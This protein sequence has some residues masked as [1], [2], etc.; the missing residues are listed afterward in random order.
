MI[1]IIVPIYKVELYLSSC[2]D[3]ILNQTYKDFEVILVDDGSPDLCPVICDEYAKKDKRIKVVHKDNG[4][5]SSARNAGLEIARGEYIAFVDS[6]DTI[7]PDMLKILVSMI[8][9]KDIA[10]CGHKEVTENNNTPQKVD[11]FKKNEELSEDDL[12]NEIFCK[13]NNAVWNKLYRKSLIKELR[14]P[15]SLPHGEDLFFNL[16]YLLNCHSGALNKSPL[17]Y[18]LKRDG[19]VTQSRFSKKRLFEI[20][21]KDLALDFIKRY[22][23]KY[24]PYAELF[25]FRSRMNVLRTIY[26]EH[27]QVQYD[28]EVEQMKQYVFSN[29]SQVKKMMRIKEQFEFFLFKYMSR[30]YCKI[31]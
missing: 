15:L 10:I 22:R 4:G 16:N 21:S 24:I 11:T 7:H 8:A 27:L 13:L 28:T 30:L 1:S 31:V 25:S 2:I 18:Y 26:H 19:S 6:D 9:Q 17:Y 20:R 29:Y 3:S 14:F 12:W 23:S 5:Q